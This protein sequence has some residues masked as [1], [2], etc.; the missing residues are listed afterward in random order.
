MSSLCWSIYVSVGLLND[1]NRVGK[2]LMMG[3]GFELQFLLQRDMDYER[4]EHY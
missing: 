2:S 4:I 3:E 1:I